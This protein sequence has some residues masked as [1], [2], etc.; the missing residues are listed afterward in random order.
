MDDRARTEAD[1][2]HDPV[3]LREERKPG[4]EKRPPPGPDANPTKRAGS[5]LRSAVLV[6]LAALIAY[7]TYHFVM[8]ERAPQTGRPHDSVAAQPVGAATIAT[9]DIKVVVTGLGTVTPLANVTVKTQVNGQLTEVAFTEGQIVKKGD[10]LAQIDPRPYQLAESQYE[11]QLVHDQGLLDQAK[12]DL[13]RYQ[14]LLKQ[15]SIARQTAEDQVYLVKQYEG[16]VKTDQAQI[17]TQKLNLTYARIVSPIDGR[18]GL[19]L[20]D[21]RQLR[22]DDRY[23]HRGPDPIASDLGDLHRAGG[24]HPGNHG[25]AEGGNAARG[26]DLRSR[27]RQSAGRRQSP[28]HRQSDRH[29]DRH[30]ED[31]RRVRQPRRQIVSQSVRQC[32]AAYK[33]IERRRR[34]AAH[35][36]STRRARDLCLPDRRRQYGVGA[37]G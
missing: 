19:R 29:D 27:Q 36:H 34:R 26:Y 21:R 37:Q 1:E 35:R 9:G 2:P 10:F 25:A 12:T 5:P 14:A 13:D 8:T 16:S 23:R 30:R 11:G 7:A 20:V 15:N 31:P 24:R 4:V 22:A 17:D 18:V 32:A 33:I 28:D 6:V 3:F